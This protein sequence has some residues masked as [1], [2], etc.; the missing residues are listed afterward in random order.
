M[1]KR[2]RKRRLIAIDTETTGL[3]YTKDRAIII[4]LSTGKDR[5]VIFEEAFMYLKEFLEDPRYTWVMWNAKFDLRML[6]NAGLDLLGEV[7]QLSKGERPVYRVIDMMVAHHMVDDD[8]PHTLKYAA[9]ELLDIRM[10]EFTE[11][12]G[13]QMKKRDLEEIL[14]DPENEHIVA[15]YAGL[16]AWVTA[17]CY[18]RI[19]AQLMD[20]VCVNS[21]NVFT[22]MQTMWDLFM[23]IE[24]PFTTTLYYCERAGFRIDTEKLYKF[25]GYYDSERARLHRA[26]VRETLNPGFN[27]QSSKDLH[28][29]LFEVR[30]HTPVSFTDKGSPQTDDKTL[31]AYAKQGCNLSKLVLEYRAVGKRLKTYVTAPLQLQKDGVIYARFH[32]TGARTGRLSSSDPN[33]Q[34]QPPFIREAFIPHEGYILYARDYSQLEVRIF[35]ALSGDKT[36]QDSISAGDDPHSRVASM[37]FGVPYELIHG[38]KEKDDRGEQLT[39]EEKGYLGLRRTTKALNFGLL[40]GMSKYRL[41]NELG[42]EVEVA[43]AHMEQYFQ[44]MPSAREAQTKMISDAEELGYSTTMFGNRRQLHGF[45]SSLWRDQSKSERE[46][47]NTPI[48]GSAAKIAA[49]AMIALFEDWW[50]REMGVVMQVQVHDEI[51]FRIPIKYKLH[52]PKLYQKILDRIERIMGNPFGLDIGVRLETTGKEGMTWLEAK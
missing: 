5:W 27:P 16:D 49:L 10:K 41:A 14:L 36:L 28:H 43:D 31:K 39:N 2:L 35:A 18:H 13:E 15:H 19:K 32:Q 26:L 20:E 29:E 46:A 23:E 42:V 9:L 52:N 12:F 1:V 45:S 25:A 6:L 8:R 24:V 34:N 3:S 7:G 47:K 51:V 33:L 22:H 40:Y 50:L 30:G 38:A 21:T 44:T 4:S 11:V 17:Q 48:Q 37:M